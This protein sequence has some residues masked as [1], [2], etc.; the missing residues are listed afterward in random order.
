MSKRLLRR[1]L[2]YLCKSHFSHQRLTRKC[3]N[4]YNHKGKENMFLWFCISSCHLPCQLHS[5]HKITG[6]YM[7]SFVS[8]PPWSSRGYIF[9]G[10]Y[11]PFF[12]ITSFSY[13]CFSVWS[14]NS[15]VNHVL[16]LTTPRVLGL[17]SHLAYSYHV[18][19]FPGTELNFLLNY[20]SVTD[21]KL[22]N[23]CNFPQRQMYQSF[24]SC[25]DTHKWVS[26]LE[27]NCKGDVLTGSEFY[28][29]KMKW[30]WILPFNTI[31]YRLSF[32]GL[33]NCKWQ[34]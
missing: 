4:L 27:Q 13:A 19:W 28:Q 34:S 29:C 2:I 8:I 30:Y 6:D 24:C 33:L 20:L 31:L 16:L 10:T 23:F 14:D 21:S 25:E 7:V 15:R 5:N 22:A 18:L 17:P 32:L 9:S 3:I 26:T 1:H 11:F 12:A